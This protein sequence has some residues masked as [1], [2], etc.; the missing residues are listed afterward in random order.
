MHESPYLKKF[1]GL[2]S[3]KQVLGILTL[4]PLLVFEGGGRWTRILAYIEK[5]YYRQ[6]L[7][8]QMHITQQYST[9]WPPIESENQETIYLSWTRRSF[10]G[11]YEVPDRR[12]PPPY[13]RTG[14]THFT[15]S[16]CTSYQLERTATLRRP[17]W[18]MCRLLWC[19]L[20]YIIRKLLTTR[21]TWRHPADREDRPGWLGGPREVV[22][23]FPGI[24]P[25]IPG[26]GTLGDIGPYILYN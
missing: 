8:V 1:R 3:G 4:S 5:R 11:K 21:T 22:P 23:G 16:P 7:D 18:D 19:G 9:V 12:Y 20:Y 26:I 10:G 14:T 6:D 15:A 2:Y 24:I 25:G 17:N 13:L